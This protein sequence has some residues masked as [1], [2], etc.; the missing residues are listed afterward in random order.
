M[1]R[2]TSS[3]RS[4]ARYSSTAVSKLVDLVVDLGIE[5]AGSELIEVDGHPR[6]LLGFRVKYQRTS[7]GLC[8]AIGTVTLWRMATA[9]VLT[10]R[11]D[12]FPR[13]YQ[14]VLA[15]AELAETGPVRGTMVSGPT[16]PRSGSACGP[17][18]T[19]GSRHAAPRTPPSPCSAPSRTSSVRPA[20]RRLQPRARGRRRRRRKELDEPLVARPT[21]EPLTGEYQAQLEVPELPAPLPLLLIQCA[22]SFDRDLAGLQASYDA[23]YDAYGQVFT[24]CGL[25]FRSV[26]AQSGEIGGDT[27]QEFMAVAAVGEDAF[28][29]CEHC[30]YAANTEAATAPADRRRR[31]ARCRAAHEG[32]H[33]RPARDRRRRGAPRDDAQPAAE[34]DRVRRRRRARARARPRRP[35]GQRVRAR[36]RPPRPAI[37]LYGDADFAAH[38]EL[39]KGYIGPDFAARRTS[40]PTRR[41]GR[42]SRGS[43]ART[44]STTTRPTPS[45]AAT[46]RPP[47][48]PRSWSSSPATRARAAARRCASTAAS[49]SVTSSSSAR[50]TPR[51][52]AR[53]YTGRRSW[54]ATASQG[55]SDRAQPDRHRGR[56]RAR[57]R[58]AACAL[59]RGARATS[60]R[61][62]GR[63]RRRRSTDVLRAAVARPAMAPRRLPDPRSA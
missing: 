50:S 34:G 48:G 11:A 43:P 3:A 28:V 39:P 17:S 8:P 55:C 63:R 13:R 16:A 15:T 60:T 56:R 46:S 4:P 1:T 26:K 62:A 38:P 21:S 10:P 2:K 6:N 32:A 31:A 7:Q 47:T 52:S 18:W 33:P 14:D 36:A 53:Y 22:Y 54:A 37:R 20:R 40:S 27:S 23:M 5:G 30:D 35:R 19:P 9:P 45:S 29:W 49:R 41:Y 61:G 51:P 57:D 12:D 25:T 42:R 24:R 58:S 44:R 59:A